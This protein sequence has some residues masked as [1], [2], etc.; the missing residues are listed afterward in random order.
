MVILGE[1]LI[2]VAQLSSEALRLPLSFILLVVKLY[3]VRHSHCHKYMFPGLLKYHSDQ[4]QSQAP[5]LDS[6]RFRIHVRMIRKAS[7][8]LRSQ[9]EVD[10]VFSHPEGMGLKF[11]RQGRI[12]RNLTVCFPK[13]P[14]S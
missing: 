3:S 9:L 6:L 5:Y 8:F 4:T 11:T 2:P 10:S 12:R 7:M 14:R 1:A 13:K